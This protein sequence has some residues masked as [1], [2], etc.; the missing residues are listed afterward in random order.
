MKPITRWTSDFVTRLLPD[1][2]ADAAIGDLTEEYVLRYHSTSRLRAA[3][4]YCG[5]VVRSIP[6]L[7]WAGLRREGW[8]ATVAVAIGA[9]V[10]A[11]AAESVADLA[12]SALLASDAAVRAVP[13]FAIGMI[14]TAFGGYLA[15]SIRRSAVAVLA[16]IVFLVV[17]I[18]ML[19]SSEPVPLWYQI[20]FLLGGPLVSMAGGTWRRTLS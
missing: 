20:G 3:G 16:A 13:G 8:L 12:M 6:V 14:A 2:P 18:L 17:V 10:A 15:A 1:Q 19:T 11:S 4:W 9:Y 5:Q 7:W